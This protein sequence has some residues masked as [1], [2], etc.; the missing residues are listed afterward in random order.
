M[1]AAGISTCPGS[2]SLAI[3]KIL[4]PLTQEGK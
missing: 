2:S 3:L 1:W 4:D